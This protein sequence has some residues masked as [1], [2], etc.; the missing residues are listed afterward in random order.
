MESLHD[1]RDL[2]SVTLHYYHDIKNRIRRR[3][4]LKNLCTIRVYMTYVIQQDESS[5]MVKMFC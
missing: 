2:L 4:I 1:P 3:R 5:D